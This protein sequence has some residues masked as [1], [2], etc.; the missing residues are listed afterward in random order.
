METNALL[1]FEELRGA[2]FTALPCGDNAPDFFT[3][4]CI[5]SRKAQ[6]GS[7]FFALK[8]ERADGH[9]FVPDAV[10]AGA[11]GVVIEKNK[12]DVLKNI[13]AKISIIYADD[14]LAA[15]QK[16]AALYV[17]KFDTLFKIGITGSSGK[18]T[19]KEI[20]ASIFA[21][22]KNIVYNEGNLN[23]DS[24]LPLSVF[25]IRKEHETGIFEMGMNRRG[26]M[27]E[28]A[29]VLKPDAALITNIGSAHIGI[30]GSLENIAREKKDI[31]IKFTGNETLFVPDNVPFPDIFKNE[32]QGNVIFYNTLETF[33]GKVESLGLEGSVIHWDGRKARF[34]LPGKHNA[35]N[36]IAAIA[37]ARWSGISGGAVAAGLEA[38]KPLFGRAQA[39]EAQTKAGLR[40]MLVRDCYNANPASMEKALLMCD[41]LQAADGGKYPQK[42]Y[43]IGAMREL[44]AETESEHRRLGER[45]SASGADAVFLFGE[46]TEVTAAHMAECAAKMYMYQTNDI[47]ALIKNV[48]AVLRTG[49]LILLK[50]SRSCE[51]ERVEKG[52]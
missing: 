50:G 47:D 1:K 10:K 18:T 23:S 41:E 17:S 27:A 12:S 7:L 37:L 33:T 19:V 29:A 6:A 51:L 35:E 25:N 24:G 49:A 22:E 15:L 40:Y 16:I 38:V 31:S 14:T 21:R 39:L 9:N 4:V 48:R 28:I 42:I 34:P 26:E 43:I 5:D 52:L 30:I 2:G 32:V 44:G 13:N 45:L 36:A 46:E 8:G 3:N 11:A 20:C